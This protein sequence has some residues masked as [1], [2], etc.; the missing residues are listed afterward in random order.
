MTG[1]PSTV[2]NAQLEE[3]GIR[4]AGEVPRRDR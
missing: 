2:S 4:I 3:L 1:S